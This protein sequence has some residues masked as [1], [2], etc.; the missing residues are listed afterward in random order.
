[1]MQLKLL[2]MCVTICDREGKGYK[3]PQSLVRWTNWRN[4]IG[5][6]APL[7]MSMIAHVVGSVEERLMLSF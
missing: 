2:L 6:R 1:M 4:V 5:R 7:K 3:F